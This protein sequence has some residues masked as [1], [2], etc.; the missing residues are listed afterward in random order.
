MKLIV[1]TAG[2]TAAA[3]LVACGSSNNNKN[4]APPTTTTQAPATLAATATVSATLTPSAGF[5]PATPAANPVSRV[6]GAVQSVS[7]N[8]V[9]LS[10]GDSFMLSPQTAITMRTTTDASAFQAGKTVAITAKQQPDG[11]LLASMIV[12]FPT[13]P[14]GGSFFGQRPLDGGNLM[15]NAT[16]DKVTSGGFSAV[17]PGGGAQVT[18]APDVQILAIV[19]GSAADLKPG[20]MVMA[21]VQNGVAQTVS[22]Q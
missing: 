17:F 6:S 7:G 11:T 9:T 3:L 14:G 13:A 16:I 5:R 18:L 15:T 8:T 12:I 4:T 21:G 20:V 22:V 1:V 10:Q 19:S 2:V